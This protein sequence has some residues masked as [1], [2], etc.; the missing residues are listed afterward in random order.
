MRSFCKNWRQMKVST[1]LAMATIMVVVALGVT[2]GDAH[3]LIIAENTSGIGSNAPG[4]F[5][6]TL[7]TPANPLSWEDI[8]LNFWNPGATTP[9]AL[10]TLYLL[11]S[12]YLGTPSGLPGAAGIIATSTGIVGGEWVYD[13][14]VTISPNTAYWFYSD[15]LFPSGT[16]SG[17]AGTVGYYSAAADI[18]FVGGSGSS[19][20]YRLQG[21]AV[22]EPFT[23]LLLGT[24][25]VGLAGLRR[26]FRS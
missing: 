22:P 13:A 15:A 10:G 21:N 5:G 19:P 4:Y 14:G 3:A 1:K 23:I 20:N 16:I 7:T 9:V 12:E 18:N 25:L 26:K 8:T 11:S 2:T 24:G 6:L 17:P